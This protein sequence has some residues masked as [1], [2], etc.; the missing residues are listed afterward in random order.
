M[1]STLWGIVYLNTTGHNRSYDGGVSI[2]KSFLYESS[3]DLKEEDLEFTK[4]WLKSR[5]SVINRVH[6]SSNKHHDGGRDP[7]RHYQH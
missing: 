4:I 2:S 1:D 7:H 6:T 3:L 5:N